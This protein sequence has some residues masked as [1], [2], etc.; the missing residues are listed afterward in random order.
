VIANPAVRWLLGVDAISADAASVRLA[1]ERPF[2]A[3]AWVCVLGAAIAVAWFGYRRLDAP[4][5]ARV[6]LGSVRAALVLL[7]ALLLSGPVIELPRERSEPD[8][9]IVLADR[10]RSM[11]V[12]DVAGAGGRQSRDEAL[13]AL[14]TGPAPLL[15]DAGEAHRVMWLGFAEAVTPLASGAAGVELGEAEGDRTLLASAIEQGLARASGRPISAVVLLTDGRTTEPPD[16][17]LVRKLVDDGIP[18]MAVALGAAEALGDASVVDAQAPRRAFARDLVPVEATVE[19]RGPAATRPMRVELVDAA[20]G[21]VLDRV[22]LEPSAAPSQG[23]SR[24]DRV[25]LVAK[26]SGAGDAEWTV[27]VVDPA[28]ADDLVPAN[29][30]R[31]M[32]VTLLDRPLRAL[33]VDAYPRWEYRYLKNL[34]ARESTIESAVMLLSA[35]RDFA[36]EGNTPITRLPR[37]REEFERFDLVVIGD[38]PAGFFTDEQLREIRRLVA[39]RG[40]GLVWIGG[41]RN[42][43]RTWQGS[44]LQD[45]LPFGGAFEL[46]RLPEAVNMQPTPAA[47]RLGV[48]RLADDGQAGFPAELTD[49]QSGWSRLQWAQRI[50]TAA[51][52]PTAEV[53]ATSAESVSGEEAPLV[54]TMRYGAGSVLYLATDEIWRWRYGRGETYPE[55]FWLPLLRMM[56]R[57]ALAAGRQEVQVAVEPGRATLGDTVRVQVELPTG[58]S[59]EL[60]ALEA[61]HERA[62]VPVADLEARPEPDGTLVAMWTPEA[63]GRW[64]VRPREVTLAARATAGQLTVVRSDRELRDAEANRALLADLAR[65]TGGRLLEPDEARGLASLLPNRSMVTEDPLREPIWSSPLALAAFLLLAAAEWIGRRAVR[66]A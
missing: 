58:Q 47:G 8:T 1:F 6:A 52:K 45:L 3:W 5:R 21:T 17:A 44:E 33:Y 4:R 13:R 64:T 19:R 48:L 46:E 38:V 42:T 61:V 30:R 37:T 15:S 60:V 12:R 43:P 59:P 26:P 28:G 32:P 22:D 63:D 29:D 53:L 20:T 31:S 65:A 41:E 18:V 57:P 55:R 51:V 49:P 54:L 35:D 14:A 40:A 50:P 34:M 10:S 16:P 25:T 7:V 23:S 11:E 62:G 9:V 39:E 24:R 66:L 56:A 2:P 36:Q 27:R